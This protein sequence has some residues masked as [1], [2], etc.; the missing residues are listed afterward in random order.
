[1]AKTNMTP[2][3][4]E[5]KTTNLLKGLDNTNALIAKK[6]EENLKRVEEIKQLVPVIAK[7]AAVPAKK[8]AA[9]KGTGP[10]PAKVSKP[11]AATAPKPA[12][13]AGERPPLKNVID[14][15]L[16]TIESGKTTAAAIR[17]AA[18]AKYAAKFGKWSNQSIYNAL[19][20]DKRYKK[21][22]EGAAAIFTMV[23]QPKA[24]AAKPAAPAAGEAADPAQE[25]VEAVESNAAT[26]AVG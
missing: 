13:K 11:K 14:E 17:R 12:A 23:G 15:V 20:D 4:A 21:H 1:M 16:P 18:H 9:K 22:G 24:Q 5:I 2:R 8:A 6:Q 7:A 3:Q 10:K 26:T 19:K 25:F